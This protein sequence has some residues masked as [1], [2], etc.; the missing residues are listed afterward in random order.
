MAMAHG[1]LPPRF[2]VL[3]DTAAG[4]GM[5]QGECLGLAVEDI[6]FLRGVVHIRRQVKTGR[7]KHVFTLPK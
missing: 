4:I 3:V 7:C 2:S 1:L 5:R 6:D